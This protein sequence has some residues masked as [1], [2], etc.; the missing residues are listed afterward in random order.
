[1]NPSTEDMLNAI[2]K[3]N[4][5]NIYILPNN[6]NIILAANQAKS[7]VEDKN[8]IVIPTKTVP[9]G[10]TALI[11]YIAEESV[12]DN[13]ARMTEEIKNV[14]SGQV[15]YAVRDTEIDGK[16]IKENDI[17]GISDKGIIAVSQDIKTTTIDML[18]EL[19]DEDSE[20]VSIY[21]GADTTEE[22]AN[23]I[24]DAIAELNSSMDVEVN[25]GGQP[26]YY[27]VVSVE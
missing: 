9:Q 11:N 13:T 15:T 22:D 23:E 6:S 3:V 7:L 2:E 1:M 25:Y 19:I 10:I 16:V 12:E 8:I 24:A 17:M 14:K 5:D 4:A 21:Y 20:I 26:I 18:K 27:Y